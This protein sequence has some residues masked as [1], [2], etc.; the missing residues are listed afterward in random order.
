[1]FRPL[2]E[3]A[4]RAALAG[5]KRVGVIDRNLCPGLGGIVWG[6]T[7]G[8]VDPGAIAQNYLVGLGGGD[9]RPAHIERILGDLAGRERAGDPEFMEAAE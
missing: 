7:R 2:P 1:M 8:L 3:E 6:E 9:I 4:L 5:K